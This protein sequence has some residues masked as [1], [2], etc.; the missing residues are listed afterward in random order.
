[1]TEEQAL[2]AAQAVIDD[3]CGRSGLQNEWDNID[4]ETQR[5]IRHEWARLIKASASW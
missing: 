4:T 3:L 1:M 5:E 2:V